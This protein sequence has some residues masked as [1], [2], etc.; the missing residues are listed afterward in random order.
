M[1]H[2]TQKGWTTQPPRNGRC[3]LHLTRSNLANKRAFWCRISVLHCISP[4]SRYLLL[5][6]FQWIPTRCCF[7]TDECGMEVIQD[8]E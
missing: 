1:Q 7:L 5:D 2:A 3:N 8:H 4:F 6:C